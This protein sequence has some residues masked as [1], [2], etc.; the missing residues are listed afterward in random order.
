[1]QTKVTV[2]PQNKSRLLPPTLQATL[3]YITNPV[4]TALLNKSVIVII[5]NRIVLKTTR[6]VVT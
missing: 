2:I 3:C 6:K 4:K 1:M 5:I